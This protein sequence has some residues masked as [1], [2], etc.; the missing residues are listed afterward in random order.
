MGTW[1]LSAFDNDMAADFLAEAAEAPSRA[2][3]RAFATARRQ[4]PVDDD[5][6]QEAW[7]A[8][9]LVAIAAGHGRDTPEDAAQ[10]A[11]NLEPTAALREAAATV[12]RKLMDPACELTKL[13]A[14][15]GQGPAYTAALA[16]LLERLG[17]DPVPPPPAPRRGDVY[18]LDGVTVQV[19]GTYE[20]AVFSGTSPVDAALDRLDGP[21]RIVPT[22]CA[23][24]L[25]HATRV[26]TAPLARRFAGRRRY[27]A[28]TGVWRDYV[29]TTAAIGTW[30]PSSYEA[31]RD[32]PL[33][34]QVLDLVPAANPDWVLPMPRPP[35]VR[36]AA[37][38]TQSGPAWAE[39]RA[40]TGP[41]PFDDPEANRLLVVRVTDAGVHALLVAMRLHADGRVGD[42]AGHAHE[43][44][45]Y[46]WAGLVAVWTGRWTGLPDALA[47]LGTPPPGADL[48]PADALV[49]LA[50]VDAPDS[51]LRAAWEAGEDGGTAFLAAV[52][53]LREACR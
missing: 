44:R 36:L 30:L 52:A 29:E 31:V 1:A 48:R 11:Q 39:L 35:A 13:W 53:A 24:A 28:E 5:E 4:N 20:A 46:L 41:G 12:V 23:L 8:A 33:H 27:S 49:F 17:R 3:R 7:A 18:W 6:A 50:R 47:G 43:R 37:L 15:A 38:R 10:L 25:K 22:W 51:E 26:G 34:H 32:L 14:E 21:A 19:L 42:G 40:S 9:E 16:H 2:V 45:A